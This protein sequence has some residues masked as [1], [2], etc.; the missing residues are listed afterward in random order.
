M[1][2]GTELTTSSKQ[3]SE[4]CDVSGV[5]EDAESQ[6]GWEHPAVKNCKPAKHGRGTKGEIPALAS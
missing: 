1:G 6:Q 4:H 2:Y 5:S 3:A